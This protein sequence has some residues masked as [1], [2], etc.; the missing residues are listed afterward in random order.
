VEWVGVVDCIVLVQGRDRGAVCCEC[1]NEPSGW[2]KC[3]NFS[4][5]CETGSISGRTLLFGVNAWKVFF[6]ACRQLFTIDW[7]FRQ[8]VF[9]F[10]QWRNSP[11]W[12]RASSLLRLYDYTQTNHNQ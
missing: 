11:Q 6:C 4:A 9:S 8:W 7:W 10:P 5:K 2:I 3:G 1:G 12:D